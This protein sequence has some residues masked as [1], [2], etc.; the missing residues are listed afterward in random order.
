MRNGPA[1]DIALFH[2]SHRFSCCSY[3][4]SK[5]IGKDTVFLVLVAQQRYKVSEQSFQDCNERRGTVFP[6]SLLRRFV[7]HDSMYNDIAVSDYDNTGFH[8][9]VFEYDAEISIVSVYTTCL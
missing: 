5:Y 7:W 9:V 3:Q 6:Q 8:C 2:W 1:E 4:A